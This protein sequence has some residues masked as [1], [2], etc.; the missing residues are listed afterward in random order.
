[1][2]KLIISYVI[3][4]VVIVSLLFLIVCFADAVI[5]GPITPGEGDTASYQE[6]IIG[7]GLLLLLWIPISIGFWKISNLIKKEEAK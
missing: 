1:M 3:R 5:N 2:I 4:T 7:Y 6:L